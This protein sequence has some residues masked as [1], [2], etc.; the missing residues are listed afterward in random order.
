[1]TQAK[2]THASMARSAGVIGVFTL[3]SRVL[4]FA[5][6][7]L[8]ARFFGT[9]LAAEAFVVSFKLPNLFRDLV[10]EGAMNAAI[11]PVLSETKALKS[12]KE[13]WELVGSLCIWIVGALAGITAFGVIFSPVV[14]G[15]VAPGFTSAPEKFALTVNLTRLILPFIFLIGFSAF[16]MGVLNTMKSFGTSALGPALQ[17]L[18]MIAALVWAVPRWG[19]E[20]MAWGVLVGGALQ[21]AIQAV[22]FARIGFKWVRGS[23][24]HPGVIKV[25]KL[26]APRVWGSAIYQMAVF[27]DT[28][29]AS[30]TAIVGDGGQSALYYSSRLFQL[31]LAIFA[32]SLSQ[33]SL[34]DLSKH[35]AEKNHTAFSA[36]LEFTIRNAVFTAL[37]A[38]VGLAVF[39]SEIIEVLFKRGAFG[40]ESVRVTS[41]ALFYYSLGLVSCAVIKVLVTGFYALQDTRT[42]VKTATMCL[43]INVILNAVFMYPLKV[44]GLALATSL[45]A[46]ANACWLYVLLV[47]KLG[48]AHKTQPWQSIFKSCASAA[49]MGGLCWFVIKPWVRA[50]MLEH[51]DHVGLIRLLT[52]VGVGALVYFAAALAAGSE[53]ARNTR[54]FFIRHS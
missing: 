32:V 53:E 39:S 17:N 36:S 4:G 54:K 19:I 51:G 9:S 7:V 52:G 45:A 33:A 48:P 8:M 15:L 37:P 31:P 35:A 10:G 46:T 40:D 34:P 24:L 6:D 44:G 22:S 41:E 16:M 26:L 50:G 25:L 12:E 2:S 38:S 14:V 20:G 28:I 43:G 18:A 27:V 11:V 23:L 30:F 47:R 5:R 1:M 13:F 49:M 29:V 3:V 42:P 21:C